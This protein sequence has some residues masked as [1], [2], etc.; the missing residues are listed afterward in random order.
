MRI[1]QVNPVGHVM[2]TH[3]DC[4]PKAAPTDSLA[5]LVA[6]GQDADAF[7]CNVNLQVL[8]LQATRS[9][10]A[11]AAS[12]LERVSGLKPRQP[13]KQWRSKTE[14]V[15]ALLATDPLAYTLPPRLYTSDHDRRQRL[16]SRNLTAFDGLAEG[17][18]ALKL[19][20][21]DNLRARAEEMRKH[22]V[23]YKLALATKH[24]EA[25]AA[26]EAAARGD[27]AEEDGSAGGHD[28]ARLARASAARVRALELAYLK[29][30]AAAAF[31]A[32][33]VARFP[34]A[35]VCQYRPDMPA[36]A[37]LGLN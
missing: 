34:R 4:Y 24:A 2:S 6:W 19:A 5:A 32:Q 36:R 13:P 23:E 11:Q 14:R 1:L 17:V 28:S 12:A 8:A 37:N 30:Q 16:A 21:R 33:T 10:D 7:H 18:S 15:R 29:R 20:R 22:K 31:G 25:E 9:G 27:A 3:V 35:Y 26:A